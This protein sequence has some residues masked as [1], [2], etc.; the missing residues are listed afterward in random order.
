M[1]VVPLGPGLTA[2]RETGDHQANAI[3]HYS[4]FPNSVFNNGPLDLQLF[5]PVP[6]GVDRTR[7]E[8]WNMVYVPEPDDPDAAAYE[9]Q[10]DAHWA[11]LQRVVGEDLFIFGEV[12]ATRGSMGYSANRFNARECKPT[13]FHR[14]ID[15]ILEGIEHP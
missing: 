5:H 14:H 11:G 13:A 7:F 1:M 8:C 6:L 12:G 3:C 9:R 10:V 2:L 4:I 15:N